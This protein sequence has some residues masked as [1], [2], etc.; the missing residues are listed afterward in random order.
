MIKIKNWLSIGCRIMFS[1]SLILLLIAV[2]ERVLNLAGYSFLY[3][4]PYSPWRLL[5]FATVFLIFVI[6]IMLRQ[7]REELR[8]QKKT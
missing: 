6:T 4:T 7:I 5:E 8:Q 2:G 1:I 3:G